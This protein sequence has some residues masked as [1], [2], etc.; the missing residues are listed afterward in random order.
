MMGDVHVKFG[1][2]GNAIRWYEEALRIQ[3]REMGKGHRETVTTLQALEI[4]L[5]AHRDAASNQVSRPPAT[6]PN[7]DTLNHSALLPSSASPPNQ[8][9]S[10]KDTSQNICQHHDVG[11]GPNSLPRPG[12]VNPTPKSQNPKSRRRPGPQPSVPTLG[13]PE[14]ARTLNQLHD[15]G[16]ALDYEVIEFGVQSFD[17]LVKTTAYNKLDVKQRYLARWGP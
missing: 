1:E 15:A 8:E 16:V 14:P 11:L 4:A 3:D 17:D 10:S 2:S 9:P 6:R 7:L 5:V 13:T 12:A